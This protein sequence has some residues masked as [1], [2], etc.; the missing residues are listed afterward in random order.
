[1]TVEQGS[2]Y[3]DAGATADGGETVTTSGTVD[4]ST[5]GEYT[6]TYSATDSA[7][8]T[9]TATRTVN[10]VNTN[11]SNAPVFISTA[12]PTIDE[13]TTAVTTLVTTDDDANSS[14]TYS[15]TGGADA[16]SFAVEQATGVL[17]T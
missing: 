11:N 16:T 10:V 5:I 1:M 2:S 15:I 6:I 4:E 17:N 13:N 7:G 9:G 12:T 8:N 14:V 3:V